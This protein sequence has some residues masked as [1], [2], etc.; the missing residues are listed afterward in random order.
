MVTG[1]LDLCC[2]LEITIE[3]CRSIAGTIGAKPGA[4]PRSLPRLA[5]PRSS[6][7]FLK[8]SEGP[9]ALPEPRF[10]EKAGASFAKAL[11]L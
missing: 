5:R 11:Q 10:L 2:F 7:F 3:R 4:W 9:G 1:D 6:T 8:A